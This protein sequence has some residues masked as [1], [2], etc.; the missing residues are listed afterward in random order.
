MYPNLSLVSLTFT[1]D[2]A[3]WCDR[4][5]YC[6]SCC[7]WSD[8]DVSTWSGKR[9]PVTLRTS[10]VSRAS[11]YMRATTLQSFRVKMLFNY[12]SSSKTSHLILKCLSNSVGPTNTYKQ[13]GNLTRHNH[14]KMVTRARRKDPAET[15]TF[16][17]CAKL[18]RREYSYRTVQRDSAK[19][20]LPLLC[21]NEG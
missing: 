12:W 10:E 21:T 5:M 1:Y 9:L 6:C 16:L 2:N 20:F 7:C 18:S 17:P 15:K 11:R 8:T 3:P 19:Y 13:K 14:I 4:Q